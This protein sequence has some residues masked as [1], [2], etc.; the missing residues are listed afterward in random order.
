VRACFLRST[1]TIQSRTETTNSTGEVEWTWADYKTV[2]ASVEPIKG[3]EYFAAKQL[4]AS[5][6]TRIKMRYL[7]D[8]TTKMRIKH[9]TRFYAIE[10][11]IDPFSKHRE[12]HLMCVERE[13]DGWRD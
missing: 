3:Q 9:G 1:V 4:Q 2:R 8:I 10:A 6:T 7:S 11:V 5:T 12:L 13:A